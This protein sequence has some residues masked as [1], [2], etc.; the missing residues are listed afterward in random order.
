[1]RIKTKLLL[2]FANTLIIFIIA[3]AGILFVVSNMNA[4]NKG[5]L[6][7]ETNDS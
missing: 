2:A 7:D 4:M 1:M 5:S 6:G 3:G